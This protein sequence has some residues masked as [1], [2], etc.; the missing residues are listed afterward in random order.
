VESFVLEVKRMVA[1]WRR[2]RRQRA[3]EYIDIW[4]SSEE[5]SDR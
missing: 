3:A 1:R 4:G 2:E 5:G